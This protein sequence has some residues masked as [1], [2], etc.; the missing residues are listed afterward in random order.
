MN[1]ENIPQPDIGPQKEYI[2]PFR[3]Q[4]EHRIEGIDAQKKLQEIIDFP[5]CKKKDERTPYDIIY[6]AKDYLERLG[7][8]DEGKAK[9]L[10]I[11]IQVAETSLHK[12]RF[13][14]IKNI[15]KVYNPKKEKRPKS[16]R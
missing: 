9:E 10:N 16:F 4:E 11:L 15:M 13:K 6:A 14:N 5:E 3:R 12:E 8:V 1:I 2:P 7:G